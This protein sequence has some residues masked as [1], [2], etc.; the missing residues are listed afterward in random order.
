MPA[1][2]DRAE[3]VRK[4]EIK[5]TFEIRARRAGPKRCLFRAEKIGPLNL[6]TVAATRPKK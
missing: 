5:M 3:R 4:K 6:T 1:S 2:R